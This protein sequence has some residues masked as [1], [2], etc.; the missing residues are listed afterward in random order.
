MPEPFCFNYIITIHNKEHLI[1]KVMRSVIA[2]CRDNS[3]IYPVLDG[4]TDRTEEIIDHIAGTFENIPITKISTPNVHEILSINAGLR[5]ASHEGEGFNIILQDD[6]LLSDLM[7]E[8]KVVALYEWAGQQLGF[9]SFRHGANFI[10][11]AVRL[12]VGVPFQDY[13]ENAYGHGSSNAQVLLPGQF[14]Y[15]TVSIKSP[16]CIPFYL[17]RSIGMLD[18][19]LAP[20][21]HDDTDYS[22]RSMKAGFRNAVFAIRFFSD[23]EWGG[24]R[25][26]PHPRLTDIVQRN[27]NKI[28]EWH[29]PYLETICSG[30]QP[31]QILQGLYM[32]DEEE[33]KIALDA[34]KINVKKLKDYQFAEKVNDISNIKSFFKR[35][36]SHCCRLKQ[37]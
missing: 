4:C 25:E 11:D 31:T 32:A 34:W 29:G 26:N 8:K 10:K 14:S 12:K 23:L 5:A 9:V 3:H 36:R 35:L 22:I 37:K 33:C 6:V 13:M 27:M 1:E 2:C 17:V 16:I 30:Q 21:M 28:R 24:T 7:L 15:R 19:R 20:C 18:E